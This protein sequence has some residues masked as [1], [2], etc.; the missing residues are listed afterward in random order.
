MKRRGDK[1][2]VWIVERP[3]GSYPRRRPT[4]REN[5]ITVKTGGKYTNNMHV[6]LLD[7]SVINVGAADICVLQS[8]EAES[9]LRTP[10][11]C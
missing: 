8:I 3:I 7:N 11:C 5:N 1:N 10:A 6:K 2:Y 4:R 9:A